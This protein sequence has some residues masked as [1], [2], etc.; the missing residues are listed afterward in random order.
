MR[1][2]RC[3]AFFKTRHSCKQEEK[4]YID[5]SETEKHQKLIREQKNCKEG[6]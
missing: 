6:F 4:A 2:V 5:V 3:G 1:C